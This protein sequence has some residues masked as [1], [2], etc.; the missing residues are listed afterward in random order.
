MESQYKKIGDIVVSIIKLENLGV[1]PTTLIAAVTLIVIGL[2]T[3]YMAPLSFLLQNIQLFLF[4]MIAILITM[5]LGLIILTQLLV[6]YLQKLILQIIM[7]FSC[8]DKKLHLIVLKN[9]EGHKRRNQQVSIMF[10]VALG[11][12]IFSGCTLN[13]VVDFAE[14]L[15]KGLIGGDFSVY[16]TSSNG[17]N[18]T[19]NEIAIKK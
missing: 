3:Y 17:L 19:L 13:L 12:V 15:S 9:L 18:V 7:L 2:L 5:L 10:M 11:F 14:T 16:V 8:K 4:I 1:S 6:P